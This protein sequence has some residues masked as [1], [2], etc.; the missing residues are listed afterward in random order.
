MSRSLRWK[1]TGTYVLLV[2]F[3]LAIA[4]AVLIP[5]ISRVYVNDYERAVLNE[6]K[7]TARMLAHY[8]MDGASI[9]RLDDI[10][11]RSSWRDGVYIGVKDASGQ[12]PPTGQWAGQ[13]GGPVAP[14][15]ASALA[16][17]P[18]T[19]IRPDRLGEVRIFAA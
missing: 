1:L 7:T 4:A 14:E 19:V 10:A 17:K 11:S 3:S 5:S 13:V 8:Q 12:P 15:V 16:D 2:L 9:A 6:A 18:A